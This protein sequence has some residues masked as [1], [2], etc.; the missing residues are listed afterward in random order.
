M[1]S[2]LTIVSCKK[3]L[4]II[5]EEL[6]YAA[7]TNKSKILVTQQQKIFLQLFYIFKLFFWAGGW[8]LLMVVTLGL[9]LMKTSS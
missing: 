2:R 7:A 4:V 3:Q 9:R 5:Q 8:A 1:G 6:G